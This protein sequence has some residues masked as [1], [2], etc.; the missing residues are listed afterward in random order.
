M[1]P[2]HASTS[3]GQLVHM[4]RTPSV[5]IVL[6]S[7]SHLFFQ[8]QFGPSGPATTV[9]RSSSFFR[10][11]QSFSCSDQDHVAAIDRTAFSVKG[12]LVLLPGSHRISSW[13]AGASQISF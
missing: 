8:T 5:A 7:F 12:Y 2:S 10:S 9:S 1:P 11:S 6:S 13:I 3:L 4:N